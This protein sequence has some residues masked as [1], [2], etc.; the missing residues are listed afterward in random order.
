[1][2][3][4]ISLFTVGVFYLIA[5]SLYMIPVDFDGSSLTIVSMQYWKHAVL[6]I[7]FIGQSS[8]VYSLINP[9]TD[10]CHS[11]AHLVISIHYINVLV[12]TIWLMCNAS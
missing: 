8:I 3:L 11:S 1:M 6:L 5:S 10:F 7:L 9:T 2:D 4:G 12:F